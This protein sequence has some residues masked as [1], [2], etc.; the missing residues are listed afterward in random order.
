MT[1]ASS[2]IR[3][4]FSQSSLQDYSDCPRRFQ[5]RYVD[6]MP[7]PAVEA[8]LSAEKESRQQEGLRF[9]R[10]VHQHRMG[11]PSASLAKL[12]TSEDLRR[13]W[14]NYVSAD[15]ALGGYAQRSEVSLFCS[16]GD[17]RLVAKYDLI[18]VKDNRAVIYDWKTYAR[19]PP[20]EWLAARMQTRVYRALLVQAGAILN[21]G[22]PFRPDDITM[23]Y[24]FAEFPGEPVVFQYDSRQFLADWAEL[25][26]LIAEITAERNFPVT[27]DRTMC[28]WCVYRSYCDRGDRAAKWNEVDEDSP[29]G[30]SFDLSFDQIE[31]IGS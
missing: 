21:G 28:R 25:E 1:D 7:W 13:W 11:V 22:G 27:S 29:G 6:R 23:V 12:A 5:L 8:E 24:W 16:V 30:E 18:A 14:D 2:P 17:H 26:R 4:E 3:F 10:L 15:L 31:E 20:N 19:R 9:H